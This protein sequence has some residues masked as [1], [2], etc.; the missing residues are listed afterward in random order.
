MICAREGRANTLSGTIGC[1]HWWSSSG[2]CERRCPSRPVMAAAMLTWTGAQLKVAAASLG[3]A[4][5]LSQ[6]VPNWE[7]ATTNS[8]TALY[9]GQVACDHWHH[10]FQKERVP[11]A[12][13]RLLIDTDNTLF[14]VARLFKLRWILF[15]RRRNPHFVSWHL[16]VLY[17]QQPDQLTHE[18]YCCLP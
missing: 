6:H 15:L 3:H 13:G 16:A 18:Y 11:C 8:S 9:N 12:A 7:S 2:T 5:H 1:T 14:L 17:S 4:A 10:I